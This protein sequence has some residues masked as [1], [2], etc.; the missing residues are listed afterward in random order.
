[1]MPVLIVPGLGGSGAQHW[2]THL[3][4]SLPG[5]ARVQQDDWDRPEL[6]SWIE[7]LACAVEAQP[8]SILVAHSLA[9]PLVAHL[10]LRR[11]DVGGLR[12]L[13][14]GRADRALADQ[15]ALLPSTPRRQ[16]GSPAGGG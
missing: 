15:R 16:S 14:G 10:A 12:S 8:G 4:Q 6:N 13:A 11:P 1:M 7:R 2:Q 9:C 5:A 3:E